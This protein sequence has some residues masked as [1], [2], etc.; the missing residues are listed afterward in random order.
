MKKRIPYSYVIFY[1]ERKYYHLIEKELKEKGY[2][3]IKV[4]IPTLDILKRT[5]KGKMVFESVPIL[6]NYG[7]MRMPTENA[8]SRPF[9][10]KLKRNISGIR[11]FLKSTETMHERKKKVRIDNA[12]DFDDFSLVATC[13]RKDVR[14]F[15]RLAKANKKYSVDDLMNV[16]PGD[17]I[18]LKGYPYEGIDATV[19][20][21]NYLNRTVKVL[22]Y[23]EHGKME[24]TLD[25]DS[26][27][28]S[29][30]QDSDPDKLHCNNF[31]YDPNSITSE[32]IEENI[33]KRRR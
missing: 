5:V 27:L 33:N 25:F 3:N 30:Y 7:F 21:V 11:T 29:V 14:R 6:F 22:I 10:N 16:K 23:P 20:D 9:L 12:E 31:D 24:V 1:L 19:L 32:K 2:E 18:V 17:Y 26:V 13:S 8:F 28:Y 4:I 15:I